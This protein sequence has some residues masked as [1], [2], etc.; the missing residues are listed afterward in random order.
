MLPV[1]KCFLV[2]YYGEDQF[3]SQTNYLLLPYVSKRDLY[4]KKKEE[5]NLAK[6]LLI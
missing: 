6:L 4:C 2:C 5:G 3:L 1:Y